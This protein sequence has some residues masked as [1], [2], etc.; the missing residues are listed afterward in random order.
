MAYRV[1]LAGE[2]SGSISDPLVTD[3]RTGQAIPKSQLIQRNATQQYTQD[4]AGARG[5]I[6][7]PD[8]YGVGG[9]TPGGRGGVTGY[10]GGGTTGYGGGGYAGPGAP[11]GNNVVT[12]PGGGGGDINLSRG[13]YE[14]QQAMQLRAKLA[15]DAMERIFGKAGGGA[16]GRVEYG[17]GGA[18]EAARSAT[19][20][21]A[22]EQAGMNANAALTSLRDV[23]GRRGL[24]GSSIE[25][26]AEG[27]VIQGGGSDISNV[28][29]QQMQD[30]LANI[31]HVSDTTYQGNIAQRGQD[32]SAKQ[33]LMS[34]LAGLY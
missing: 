8:P 2:T 34:V 6:Y 12:S 11:A 3:P 28:I 30:E 23:M 26:G 16:E 24:R 21:R 15:N 27:D 31:Q 29:S 33:A 22:K 32:L 7:T 17:G 10:T 5:E 19:F 18:G 9:T 1:G 13:S 4:T 14:D 25:A 20:A